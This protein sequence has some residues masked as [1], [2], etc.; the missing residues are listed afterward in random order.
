MRMCEANCNLIGIFINIQNTYK[1]LM[2]FRNAYH[3]P[4]DITEI[5]VLLGEL[6]RTA[7]CANLFEGKILFTYLSKCKWLC[8]SG[9]TVAGRSLKL[10]TVR[11]C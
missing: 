6:G 11:F 2:S 3:K 1:L 4:H 5:W 9:Y 10:K 8:H 7:A